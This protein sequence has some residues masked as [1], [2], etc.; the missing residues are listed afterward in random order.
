MKLSTQAQQWKKIS[1]NGL[2]NTNVCGE[3]NKGGLV[4]TLVQLIKQLKFHWG[5]LYYEGN[6]YLHIRCKF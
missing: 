3:V 2:H 6:T 5:L 4:A 1:V